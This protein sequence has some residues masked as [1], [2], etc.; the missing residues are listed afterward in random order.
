MRTMLVEPG[1]TLVS[2]TDTV[3]QTGHFTVTVS[4]Y[5]IGTQ[6]TI[7][8][9]VAGLTGLPTTATIGSNGSAT[10]TVTVPT[11]VAAGTQITVTATPPTTSGLSAVSDPTPVVVTAAPTLQVA[12]VS[13]P[14]SGTATITGTGWIPGEEV[15]LYACDDPSETLVAVATAQPDGSV[16]CS[17]T[18]T[19]PQP[20]TALCGAGSETGARSPSDPALAP[21]L[22]VTARPAFTLDQDVVPA[23]GSVGIVDPT[24]FTPGPVTV[25]AIDAA[26]NPI[27]DPVSLTDQTLDGASVAMA[28]LGVG[29][30]SGVAALR[31]TDSQGASAVQPLR[32]IHDPTVSATPSAT[33]VSGATEVTLM[34]FPVGC[35]VTLTGLKADGTPTLGTATVAM[36]A[37]PTTVTLQVDASWLDT[38][39]LRAECP[40]SAAAG[41]RYLPLTA[42]TPLAVTDTPTAALDTSSTPIGGTFTVTGAGFLPSRRTVS[43]SQ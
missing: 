42:T 35:Q 39:T 21:N 37:D 38:A 8:A 17:L 5:P 3:P 27:G 12:D 30:T 22:T 18:T 19:A 2:N 10:A 7:S 23:S 24:G 15:T 14:Q 43:L 13:V 20:S 16:S 26:G 29:G 25:Q 28:D 33:Q 4:G 6:M 32:V 40:Q 31:V 36:T 41:E 11:T 34:G 1:V 9:N